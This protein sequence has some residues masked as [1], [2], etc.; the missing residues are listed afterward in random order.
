M[1]A[2][3]RFAD[4]AVAATRATAPA[5]RLAP[6]ADGAT[7]L[8]DEDL[9]L[10][11]QLL[12]IAGNETTRNSISGGVLAL[13]EHREQAIRLYEQP[14]LMPSAVEEILRWVSPVNHFRRT[15]TEDV[16]LGGKQILAG[17]KSMPVQLVA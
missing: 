5:R 4:V 15:A 13:V 9:I 16:E 11:W 3:D 7:R 17:I 1:I 10:F 2:T 12:V 6:D 14:D 8:T